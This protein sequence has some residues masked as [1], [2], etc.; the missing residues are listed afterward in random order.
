MFFLLR[1]KF[2]DVYSTHFLFETQRNKNKKKYQQ[3][4][5]HLREV[6]GMKANIL[7]LSSEISVC[8]VKHIAYG[9]GKYEILMGKITINSE[10]AK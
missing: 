9:H 10:N 7:F 2:V 1:T 3:S 8:W 6:Y 5:L 4:K